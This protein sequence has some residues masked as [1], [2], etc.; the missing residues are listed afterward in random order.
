MAEHDRLEI[1]CRQ[2]PK[3]LVKNCRNL[4]RMTLI[5][6]V[7]RSGRAPL[8]TLPPRYR[9]LRTRRH[10]N[11]NPAK[12]ASH[13][14]ALANHTRPAN[15]NQERRLKRVLRIVLVSQNLPGRAVGSDFFVI[16]GRRCTRRRH[17]EL[18]HASK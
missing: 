4:A 9:D 2:P 16:L 8:M 6:R 7:D 18:N 13:R 10:P 17:P 5:R 3:F 15:P 12:P 11:G 14:F 1:A